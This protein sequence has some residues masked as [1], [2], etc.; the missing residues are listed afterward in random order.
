MKSVK[1][2]IGLLLLVAGIAGCSLGRSQDEAGSSAAP[3]VAVKIARVRSADVTVAVTATGK[4][5]ALRQ[6]RIQPPIAGRILS[7]EVTEGSLVQTRQ[8]IARVRTR[9]SDAAIRGAAAM[10]RMATTAEQRAEAES[11]ARLA[12]SIQTVVQIHSSIDGVVSARGATEGELVD[13]NSQLFSILDLSSI[14][15]IG[16]VTIGALEDIHPGQPAWI[17]LTALPEREFAATVYAIDPQSNVQ[18]QTFQIRLHFAHL[19]EEM[20]RLLKTGLT[21]TVTIVTGTHRNALLVPKAALLRDDET[22][23]YSIVEMTRDSLAKSLPVMVGTVNDSLAEVSGNG[24]HEGLDVIIA[25]HYALEDSTRLAVLND[26]V[27]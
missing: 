14:E 2:F 15:F 23:T 10:L 17:K 24:L 8:I 5:Y 22:N 27:K 1:E 21:G 13:E 26:R 11:A 25:G 7:M 6:V 3:V 18:S 19:S 12:D 16:D 4:T 9:E 20:K